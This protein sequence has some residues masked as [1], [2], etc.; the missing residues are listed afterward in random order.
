MPDDFTYQGE[1]AGA[2]W[3][4]QFPR[5]REFAY[6]IHKLHRET[7]WKKTADMH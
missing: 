6:L 4:K 2:Q 1:S 7:S 5:F 3:V